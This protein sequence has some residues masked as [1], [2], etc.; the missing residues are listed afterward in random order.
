MWMDAENDAHLHRWTALS[1]SV[2]AHSNTSRHP[3]VGRGGD[4]PIEPPGWVVSSRA[5]TQDPHGT[6]DPPDWQFFRELAILQIQN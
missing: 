6:G 2:P 4:R 1:A 3:V 5:H